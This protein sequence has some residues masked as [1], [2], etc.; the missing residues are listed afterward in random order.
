MTEHEVTVHTFR[1]D[2]FF[3]KIERVVATIL[4]R[5]KVVTPIDVLVKMGLLD[6]KRL[7]DWRRGEV[8]FLEMVIDCNLNRL[9]RLLQIL[10]F[11]AHELNLIPSVT[12][13]KQRGKDPKRYLQFTKMGNPQL[14]EA[15]SRH[16]VWPGKGPFHPPDRTIKRPHNRNA[17]WETHKDGSQ[18]QTP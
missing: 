2:T 3:P 6:S 13:Y 5:D 12:V 7:D 9:T 15:Y 18:N 1:E 16:F 8:P 4:A 11:H 17:H 14:E 10:R